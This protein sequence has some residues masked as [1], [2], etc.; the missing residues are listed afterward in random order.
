MPYE[1]SPHMQGRVVYVRG[2]GNITVQDIQMAAEKI[3][4]YM[5]QAN[6]QSAHIF[7]NALAI[8]QMPIDITGVSKAAQTALQPTNL[9]WVI[10]VSDKG[11]IN[12]LASV[13]TQVAGVRFRPFEDEDDAWQFLLS[14]DESLQ[15]STQ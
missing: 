10:H 3:A 1:V 5:Q 4:D 7:H 9:G 8:D 11:Y 6:P 14:Q 12:F 15:E 13:V 2:E